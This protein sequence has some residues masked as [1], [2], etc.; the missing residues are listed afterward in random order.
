MTP[1]SCVEHIIELDHPVPCVLAMGAWYKNTICITRGQQAFISKC[2]GDLDT[3]EACLEHERTARTL[4]DWLGEKPQVIA[5]DLHPDFHS[6]RFAA[7]L[8]HELDVPL[9]A[10]QHHH[11]HI[12]AVC[13]EHGVSEPVLGL[14]LDG[15][16]LGTDGTAWGGELLRV[17]GAHFERIGHLRPMP[18]PGGDKAAQEPWRMAAAALYESGRGGEI[19][20]RYADE[21][22]AATVM[23]M[24]QRD[25]NCPRTSSMGR[26]FDAAAGLLGLCHKMEFEAQAAIALEQ[27]ATRN[28]GIHKAMPN[29]WRLSPKG[30]LDLLPLLNTLADIKDTG[31]GA[32][33]FHT[34]LIEAIADWIAQATQQTGITVIA[35]GGG[36]FFNKLLSGGLRERMDAMGVR[37]LTTKKLLPG[38]TAIA[39]GQ[40]W[41]ATKISKVFGNMNSLKKMIVVLA[42]LILVS[43]GPTAEQLIDV[44]AASER[45]A[46]GELLLDI[47]EA[48][49]Y[50]EFHAPNTTNIPMGRLA[51]RLAELEQY[52]GK[53]IMVIDHAE[54]RAPRAMEVLLKAGFSQVFVVKG[55]MAEWKKAGLPIEKLDM[56]VQPE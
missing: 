16:G 26:V 14:A 35:C 42:A 36:C 29:G 4:L 55:G 44:K 49:D 38:D 53:S 8:A 27:A 48:D 7:Q 34:T 54:Q 10:V 39:L 22:A 33:L 24:L 45:Q 30:E 47:R 25:F 46:R 28:I 11:A 23:S 13:A 6:S 32:V 2:V 37:M 9:I 43:C 56:Q 1:P 52:K 18:L 19:V 12:A 50:K 51:L 15:V 21:P 3:P 31:Q 40:A 5:H 17:A 20:A 41:V